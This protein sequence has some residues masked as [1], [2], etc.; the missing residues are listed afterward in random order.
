LLSAKSGIEYDAESADKTARFPQMLSDSRFW[1]LISVLF[2]FWLACIA[3]VLRPPANATPLQIRRLRAVRVRQL[4]VDMGPTFIKIG[5]F[6]SVRRD[7]LPLEIAEELALLYDR[8]PPFELALVRQTI[9]A[10]LGKSP[11]LL[12]A[13]FDSEPLASASIGQVHRVK[14]IDGRPAVIKVQRPD[15]HQMFLRDL[16]YLRLWAKLLRFTG[17]K[18]SESWLELSDEFGR[19]LFSEIDYLQEGRNADRLRRMLR[20]QPR[21]KIPR[22]YWKH[23]GRRVLTMEYMPGIKI[24]QV[25]LLESAGIDLRDLASLL[26]EGYME[27]ILYHGYFHAD[28]HPGNLAVDPDGSLIIYDFGM[29]GEISSVQRLAL[30]RCV[31]AVTKGNPAGL[32]EALIDIGVVKADARLAPVTRTVEPFIDYYRGR[33]IMSLDFQHLENDIDKLI[34][35][36]ALRLPPSLAY[37]LRAGSSLEG[38]ARTLKPNFSFVAAA[39]PVLKR[40]M[41]DQ[42][43]FL[44]GLLMQEIGQ[45]GAKKNGIYS[46]FVRLSEQD[47]SALVAASSNSTNRPSGSQLEPVDLQLSQ[48]RLEKAM[49]LVF[50]TLF[51]VSMALLFIGTTITPEFH[52]LSRYILIGNGVLGAII[53]LVAIAPP[54]RS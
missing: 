50:L 2:H 43:S 15:L 25:S 36:Q 53:I 18:R 44:G 8:V 10:D 21:I 40:W 16:G 26:I 27:Q 24:D 51:L 42:S 35:D 52:S 45:R 32:T 31:T 37:L 34:L 4:L 19:T 54:R 39:R 30:A 14:L 9:E 33:D 11:E 38:L 41:M 13:E 5:Q 29:M 22:V 23:T 1:Q 3:D 46:R 20:S 47:G 12:F 28:P 6:M 7:I 48:Y 49:R 17:K